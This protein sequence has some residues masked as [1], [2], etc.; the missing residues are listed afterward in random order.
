MEVRPLSCALDSV[1]GTPDPPATRSVINIVRL[2]PSLLPPL[3]PQAHPLG[4]HTSAHPVQDS[5]FRAETLR[6]DSNHHNEVYL[7]VTTDLLA[8][9]LKSAS[10]RPA[11]LW[12]AAPV[13]RGWLTAL[14][15]GAGSDRGRHQA[16]QEGRHRPGRDRRRV[17]PRPV[18]RRAELRCVASP[19]PP[20]PHAA[21]LTPALTRRQPN[22]PRRAA[23]AS[24]SK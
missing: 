10:V 16:R 24:A 8:K 18:A 14:R 12:R 11:S 13:A 23:S 3:R 2:P 5:I 22:P 4:P 9:A 19:P 1:M 6:L 21:C 7:E 17:V 15:D 20:P